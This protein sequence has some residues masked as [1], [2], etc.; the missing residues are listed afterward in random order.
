MNTG[1]AEC[2]KPQPKRPGEIR[3]RCKRIAQLVAQG[4]PFEE[5]GHCHDGNDEA[6]G[7]KSAR[8]RQP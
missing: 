6:K 5:Y 2:V 4:S 8:K 3:A 1:D 7:Q